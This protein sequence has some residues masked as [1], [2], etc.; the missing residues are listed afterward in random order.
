ML[1]VFPCPLV[2]TW[3]AYVSLVM[4]V[5]GA[6]EPLAGYVYIGTHPYASAQYDE[7]G[8]MLSGLYPFEGPDLL[9]ERTYQGYN[10]LRGQGWRPMV[11]ADRMVYTARGLAFSMS[12]SPHSA[13]QEQR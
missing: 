6:Q 11:F 2:L 10:W 4:G 1:T 5:A 3:V 7:N 8:R 12:A 13:R 9:P